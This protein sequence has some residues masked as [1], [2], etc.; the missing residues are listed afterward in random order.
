MTLLETPKASIRSPLS[1]LKPASILDSKT[2]RT[3]NPTTPLTNNLT[4][5]PL[6]VDMEA[7]AQDLDLV[8]D[9]PTEAHREDL[10]LL[11]EADLPNP[12]DHMVV[13]ETPV[14]VVDS[15]PNA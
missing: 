10:D 12:E 1:V 8:L 2:H 6:N 13:E 4:T 7:E 11:T 14:A 3:S 15:N 5:T 9:L